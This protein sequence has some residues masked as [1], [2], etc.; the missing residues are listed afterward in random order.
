MFEKHDIAFWVA[1]SIAT[2]LRVFMAVYETVTKTI[3]SVVAALFCA[4]FFTSPII[5]YFA[6]SDSYIAAIGGLVAITGQGTL[7]WIMKI[8]E[9]PWKLID[10]IM[11]WKGK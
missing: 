11:K 8:S 5:D 9:D 3:V 4:V 10:Y 6:L 7:R 1:V 2:G